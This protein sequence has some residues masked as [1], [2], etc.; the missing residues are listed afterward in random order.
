MAQ[1]GIAVW[2]FLLA[3]GLFLIAAVIPSLRGG[4]LNASLFV[5]GIAFLLIGGAVSRKSRAG[6]TNKST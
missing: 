1:P 3:A 6:K 5:I 2:G 4:D